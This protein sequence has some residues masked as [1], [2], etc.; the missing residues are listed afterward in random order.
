M[1][2]IN[3]KGKINSKKPTMVKLEMVFFKTG[4]PRVT[5][6]LNV[7]V[8]LKDWDNISQSFISK[9]NSSTVTKNKVLLDLRSKYQDVVEGWEYEKRIWSPIELSHYFDKMNSSKTEPKSFSA[10]HM[11]TD[12]ID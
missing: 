4:Y 6:L 1:V 3:I 10:L 9:Y 8:P 11:I 2:T 7:S 5:K 12:L